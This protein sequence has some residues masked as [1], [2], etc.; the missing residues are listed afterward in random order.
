M[1]NSQS[2]VTLVSLIRAR[3]DQTNST[4]FDDATEL[5]PWVKQSLLQLNEILI[6]QWRDYYLVRKPLSLLAGQEMYS[7]PPDFR[8]MQDVF[9]LYNYGRSRVRLRLFAPNRASRSKYVIQSAAPVAYRILRNQIWFT[10]IPQRDVANAIEL[11]YTPFFHPPLLDYSPIDDVLPNGWDEWVVL[12][13]MEKM[14][15][16]LRLDPTQTQRAKQEMLSR[17]LAGAHNRDGEPPVMLD[18][19]GRKDSIVFMGTPSGPATWVGP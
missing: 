8:A 3:S 4:T 1:A 9:L 18:V 11:H 16:K 19:S 13:V 2:V 12:D 5:R 17:L 15:N 14:N 6:Q 7:L 10:P